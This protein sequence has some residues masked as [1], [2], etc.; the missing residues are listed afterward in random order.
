MLL[1]KVVVKVVADNFLKD[2]EKLSLPKVVRSVVNDKFFKEVEIV[3]M[4]TP[5][6]NLKRR[7]RK[8]CFSKKNMCL[9]SV[10]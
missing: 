10:K 7:K 9:L 8:F 1:T 5:W 3:V 4:M 2:V 6:S